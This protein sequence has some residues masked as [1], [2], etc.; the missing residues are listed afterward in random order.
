M[1]KKSRWPNP[2]LAAK[3]RKNKAQGASP[4]LS[5]GIRASPERG[6]RGAITPPQA[7]TPCQRQSFPQPL[8]AECDEQP[9]LRMR[10]VQNWEYARR[11]SQPDLHGERLDDSPMHESGSPAANSLSRNILEITPLASIFC[12]AKAESPLANSNRFRIVA[13]ARKKIFGDR[14]NLRGE[15]ITPYFVATLPCR[16]SSVRPLSIT[17]R[18]FSIRHSRLPKSF[19]SIGG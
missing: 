10:K 4:G 3:R 6:E 18:T 2:R 11:H 14:I 15:A 1:C 17:A 19:G 5:N 13:R 12:R 8:P 16:N 9:L 7:E